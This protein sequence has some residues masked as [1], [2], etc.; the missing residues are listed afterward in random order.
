MIHKT[1]GETSVPRF[2]SEIFN[3]KSDPSLFPPL[4]GKVERN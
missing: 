2:E 3:L 4:H 1:K